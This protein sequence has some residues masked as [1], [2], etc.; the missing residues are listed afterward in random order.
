MISKK[1]SWEIG[2]AGAHLRELIEA[3]RTE[4]PQAITI[5]GEEAALV[6]SPRE[7]PGEAEERHQD[8]GAQPPGKHSR[9]VEL[10][11]NRP[12]P[13]ID[14]LGDRDYGDLRDLEL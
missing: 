13:E 5:D 3:A 12:Y 9:L 11:L 7:F 10:L 14:L 6:V 8:E 4:G 2:E 1:H